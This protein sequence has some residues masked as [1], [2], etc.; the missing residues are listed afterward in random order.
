MAV[1]PHAQFLEGPHTHATGLCAKLCQVFGDL[2]DSFNFQSQDSEEH[3][4]RT[5]VQ[6]HI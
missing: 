5:V 4:E 3:Q 6:C 1:D 2:H